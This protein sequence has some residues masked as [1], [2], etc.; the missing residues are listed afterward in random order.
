LGTFGVEFFWGNVTSPGDPNDVLGA[1]ESNQA[2]IQ[3][4][5]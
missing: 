5:F 2:P 1:C 3:T 4:F